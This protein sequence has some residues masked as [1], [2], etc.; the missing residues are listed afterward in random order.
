MAEGEVIMKYSM[1]FSS[2]DYGQAEADAAAETVKSLWVVGGPRQQEFEARFAA[3]CKADH[4]I[5]ASSWTTGA[6]LVLKA[7]N[8]GPG[9]E[10]IVP[11]LT[12]IASV[13][14]IVHAGAT[15]VFAD[16]DRNT[17]T[18]DPDDAERKI[19][20]K[21][22]AIM[23][24]DQ[25]GMPCDIDAFNTLARRYHVRILDDAA[26]AIGSYNRDRIVGS[27]AEATVFSLHARKILTTGEG[28]MIVTNDNKLADRLRLL[29]HQGMS[30]TDYQRHNGSPIVFEEYPVVGYNARL[31]DIQAAIGLA[32]MTRLKEMLERRQQIAERY[33]TFLSNHPI[34]SPPFIPPDRKPNWQ[35]YMVTVREHSSL[36]R[37]DIM[38]R[39]ADQGIPTRRGVMASHL[40][41]PY[42]SLGAILPITEK[43]AAN[44]LQLPMHSKLNADDVDKVIKA[45]DNIGS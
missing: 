26:C 14:V 36:T 4:A 11:S 6:F 32:Q 29:R 44:T 22:K 15:P 28:G 1:A 37:N 10:V 5:A 30:L 9:D 20:S 34:L 43:V 23:P 3:F 16:I 21:T 38:L 13:N 25:L 27:V 19:T 35:S 7:W 39:L 40:E 17:W 24:V 12:F 41:S 33:N 8:I 42:R 18:L 45:I 2:P 31:T